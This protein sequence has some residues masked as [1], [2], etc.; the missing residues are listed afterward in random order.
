[1]KKCIPLGL[2]T[3]VAFSCRKNYD[4]YVQDSNEVVY[5]TINCKCHK[6][7]VTELESSQYNANDTAFFDINCD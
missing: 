3:L 7:I 2:I 1:M 6:A 4:C 5:D